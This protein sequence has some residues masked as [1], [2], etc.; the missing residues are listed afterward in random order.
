MDGFWG[1]DLPKFELTTKI[2]YLYV[3]SSLFSL[4]LFQHYSLPP[5]ISLLLIVDIQKIKRKKEQLNCNVSICFSRFIKADKKVN[6]LLILFHN[7]KNKSFNFKLYLISWFTLFIYLFK[8][9][10]YEFNR[11]RI[12][13]LVPIS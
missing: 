2:I 9:K 11:H 7:K 10:I 13:Y 6:K 3:L 1:E 5:I 12:E 8:Y 4:H